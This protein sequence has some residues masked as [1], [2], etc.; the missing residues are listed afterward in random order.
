[1][2][3]TIPTHRTWLSPVALFACRSDSA[4]RHFARQRGGASLYGSFSRRGAVTATS[5]SIPSTPRLFAR[6]ICGLSAAMT[7]ATFASWS[8]PAIPSFL[9]RCLFRNCNHRGPAAHPLVVGFVQ[10][11]A[12]AAERR[13]Q[14][15]VRPAMHWSAHFPG[16]DP[17][18][19]LRYYVGSPA[20][21]FARSC[22]VAVAQLVRAPDC[23]SGGRGFKSP[24]PP[25]LT[26]VVSS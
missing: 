20:H 14:V 15:L 12:M 17:C 8:W 25:F 3:N 24:Q 21:R 23:G 18:G 1:M 16:V 9:A 26:P 2:P 13:F 22:V 10:Q 6:A 11:A 4:D 19:G 7:P 5:R